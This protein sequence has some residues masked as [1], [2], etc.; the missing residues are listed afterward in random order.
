[1]IQKTFNSQAS[2][3]GCQ[4]PRKGP[5]HRYQKQPFRILYRLYGVY[6]SY[7]DMVGERERE[8]KKKRER[9]R[10]IVKFLGALNSDGDTL[11]FRLHWFAPQQ[12]GQA[13]HLDWDSQK[14]DFFG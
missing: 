7:K 12:H 5:Q 10:E 13:V 6:I 4:W 11:Q 9:E 14:A 2:S 8:R 3:I 1:M